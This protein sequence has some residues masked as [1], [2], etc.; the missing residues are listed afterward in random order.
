MLQDIWNLFTGNLSTTQRVWTAL[1]P[2]L[3]LIVYFVGGLILY[4]IRWSFK[5]S[6]VDAELRQRSTTPLTGMWMR[7]YFA[8]L[9]RPLWQPIIRSGLPA[10]AI[11]TL[12]VLLSTAAGV[13]L[14]AGRFSLGGHLYLVS[15]I[16]DV[17]DGRMARHKGTAKPSGAALDSIMDRYSDAAVFLG[18]AWYYRD[19]W[20]LLPVLIALVGSSI[21]PYIRAK[22]EASGVAIKDVGLMQR[23]ERII[24]LGGAVALSP[25]LEV[26]LHPTDPHPMHWLAVLGIVLL[27][28]ST[29][30]TALQRLLHLLAA[31]G[32]DWQPKWAAKGKGSLGRNIVAAVVAT[33]ADFLLVLALVKTSGLAAPLATAVGC[34]LGAV[35]NYT[36]NRVWTFGSKDA[37]LPQMGRYAFVSFSSALLNAGGVAVLM[38]LPAIDYRIAW[39]LVRGAVFVAWNFPLHRDYVF[40][41]QGGSDDTAIPPDLSARSV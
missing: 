39:V 41:G 8:W 23:A 33:G 3:L 6:Y 2:T 22:A 17:V 28:I 36:T 38:M 27:A 13:A 5:G 29:Q 25:V 10:N 24:Y 40:V 11:T 18:L 19:H 26:V 15:G 34:G 9:M 1:A 16:L 7:M 30:Y 12:S 31:L 35:I 32:D 4:T 37:K 14:A 20:V 21:V